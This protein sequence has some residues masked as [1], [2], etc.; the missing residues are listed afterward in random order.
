MI[1]RGD[2]KSSHQPVRQFVRHKTRLNFPHV[3]AENGSRRAQLSHRFGPGR[4]ELRVLVGYRWEEGVRH[5]EVQQRR[6]F[7]LPRKFT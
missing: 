3:G 1:A 7:E 4:V 5:P 2:P 6:G